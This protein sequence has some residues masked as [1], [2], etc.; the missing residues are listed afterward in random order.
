FLKISYL[1]VIWMATIPTCLYYLSLLFMVELDAMR[2]G[3]QEVL[4][5]PEMTLWQMT[6][7]YGFHFVSLVAVVVFMVIGYSPMLSVF[8]STMLA[9]TMSALAPETALGPRQ[10][11]LLL[12]AILAISAVVGLVPGI[13]TSAPGEF[14]QTYFPML[15]LIT[16]GVLAVLG[17][18]PAGQIGRA[19]CRARVWVS[20]VGERVQ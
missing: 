8:Y 5:R 10:L 15:I 7:R 17:L 20:V 19:S 3:A 13:G 16:I 14:V 6:R 11:L 2:F 18:T 4:F 9:F 12:L 1:D